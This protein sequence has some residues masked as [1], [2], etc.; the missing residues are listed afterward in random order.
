MPMETV[1]GLVISERNAGENDKFISILTEDFGTLDVIVKGANK[2]TGKNHAAAQ[3]FSYSTLCLDVRKDKYYL[4]SSE[5]IYDFFNL[6]L[7]I[8]KLALACY[9]CDVTRYAILSGSSQH[10]NNIMRL[11]LNCLYMLDT[12]KRSCD[13]IKSVFELR[14]TSDIGYI[15]Q[16]IGCLNCFTYSAP[17]MYFLI[18]KAYVLCSE[19]FYRKG[20]E[21]N[22]YNV[23]INPDELAALQFICL[24]DF[25]KIFNF[26]LSPRAQETIGNIS[27]KY[28][29]TRLM[30]KF[31][32]L[33]YYY[34][35]L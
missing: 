27:E 22:Y 24:S 31:K 3:L 16:L 2:I 14:L 13:F 10:D 25:E 17:E 12:D 28:I 1:K 34:S 7:D 8:K 20:F 18:D 15:P 30:H 11:V 35:V 4:N 32:T 6:R 19:H 26:R 5:I 21:K 29:V 23:K 33:E 9:I